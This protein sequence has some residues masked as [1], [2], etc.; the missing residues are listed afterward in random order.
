M[1]Y[2]LF[3]TH[4]NLRV[5]VCLYHPS[6]ESHNILIRLQFTS[7]LVNE[8]FV[9]TNIRICFPPYVRIERW[10]WNTRIVSFFFVDV[11][12]FVFLLYF[13]WNLDAFE[14]FSIFDMVTRANNNRPQHCSESLIIL[15]WI[16]LLRVVLC[17]RTQNPLPANNAE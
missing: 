17:S 8:P 14:F 6:W 15:L 7:I 13:L 10:T 9:Y 12:V 5:C 4:R 3:R 16:P 11:V 2:T 1:C